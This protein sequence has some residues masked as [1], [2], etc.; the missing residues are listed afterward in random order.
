MATGGEAMPLTYTHMYSGDDGLTHFKEV[1]LEGRK[2][3]KSFRV[4]SDTLAATGVYFRE[5]EGEYDNDWHT[6]PN[7]TLVVVLEGGLEI[8]ASDGT[9]R[10]F[11]AGDVFLQNDPTGKG[12]Y[13]K[14]LDG[15]PRRTLFI[16][17]E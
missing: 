13:T 5:T 10:V 11:K 2:D 14:A 9:T 4:T 8:V 7:K 15:K 6:A 17:M 1:E 12:H 16:K 3:D